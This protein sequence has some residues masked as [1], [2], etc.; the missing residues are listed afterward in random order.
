MTCT[1][2]RLPASALE[3]IV[4]DV[5]NNRP[6]LCLALFAAHWHL[7][8]RALRAARLWVS[9][10]EPVPQPPGRFRVAT[11]PTQ[12]SWYPSPRV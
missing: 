6:R 3:P 7:D 11:K 2:H 5:L 8:Y 4:D 1:L 10:V 12:T 9:H